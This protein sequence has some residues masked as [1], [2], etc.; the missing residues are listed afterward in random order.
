M[1]CRFI[2]NVYSLQ[3]S[4]LELVWKAGFVHNNVMVYQ[5]IKDIGL[6]LD[7]DQLLFIV[8]LA[9]DTPAVSMREEI[10]EVI[11]SFSSYIR[12]G[13]DLAKIGLEIFTSILFDPKGAGA[14]NPS[15]IP[16][17]RKHYIALLKVTIMRGERLP[18]M[19]ALAEVR[20]ALTS[21]GLWTIYT[22]H[23]TFMKLP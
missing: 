1:C 9:K 8:G 19:L 20:H 18:S 5:V 14:V 17:G 16:L 15:L 21:S 13:S 3:D 2:K 22:N 12:Y 4:D 10:L 11:Q 7:K 23:S 6:N